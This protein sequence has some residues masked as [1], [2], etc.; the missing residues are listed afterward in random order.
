MTIDCQGQ[1]TTNKSAFQI[2]LSIQCV[3]ALRKIV[4]NNT[5]HKSLVFDILKTPGPGAYKNIQQFNADGTYS[6]SRFHRVSGPVFKEELQTPVELQRSN[7]LI[8]DNKKPGPGHY[9]TKQYDLFNS[10]TRQASRLGSAA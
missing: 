8:P 7:T 10:L 5:N 4:S 6:L 1:V 9:N 3:L 2:E